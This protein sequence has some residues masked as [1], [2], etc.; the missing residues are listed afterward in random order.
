MSAIASQITSLMIVYST[1]YSGADERK[2]QSSALLAFVRGIHRW[3]MN[4]PSQRTS[5]AQNVSIWWRHHDNKNV[6]KQNTFIVGCSNIVTWVVKPKVHKIHTQYSIQPNYILNSSSV[7]VVGY[8]RKNMWLGIGWSLM[9]SCCINH[10]P[11][12]QWRH[13]KQDG[14]SNHQP[15]DWLFNRLFRRRLKKTSK[16]LVTDLCVGNSPVTDEFPAQRASNT[17]MFPF[18]G[19]IMLV[20]ETCG[21]RVGPLVHYIIRTRQDG[22]HLAG[23]TSNCLV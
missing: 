9:F 4:S 5:Y 3:P 7:A 23:N 18:G 11:P 6:Y 16:L 13:N 8:K 17:E 10:Y 1:L 14:V 22:G 12:L 2:Y 20:L 15:H 19:V 21:Y